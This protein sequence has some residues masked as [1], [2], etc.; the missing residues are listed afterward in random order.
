M[1][2][3][4]KKKN[5][6]IVFEAGAT[7]NGLLSAKKLIDIAVFAGADA[8]K[9][10]YLEHYTDL[11]YDK[12]IK[13]EYEYLVKKH[14]E[15]QIKKHTENY[16]QIVQRR[17]L[18]EK[19]WLNVLQYAKKKRIEIFFTCPSIK[20]LEFCRK[21][22]VSSIKFPSLD[23]NNHER[24]KELK[25][26]N[27]IIQ[28]DTGLA[29]ISE[30]KNTIKKIKNQKKNNQIVVHHCPTGYPAN[31]NNINLKMIGR[32]NK[33]KNII[34]AFSDHSPSYE[35]SS[36]ALAAGAKLIEKTITLNKFTRSPEHIMS[37]EK[38]DAKI[39]VEKIRRLEVIM[40]KSD[41]KINK[42]INNKRNKW[43]RSLHIDE[44]VKKGQK[45]L[46]TKFSFKLP[47]YGIQTKEYRY[48]LNKKFTRN[49]KKHTN[50]FR[51]YLSK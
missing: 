18:T 47:G 2:Q 24:I 12:S 21:N 4:F 46:N 25:R 3:L 34:P 48:L 42:S 15:T 26:Y 22:K 37:L 49:L 36:L 6:I 45:L 33:I 14:N 32:L 1:S 17:S 19:N 27:F 30:I 7:H 5:T 23:I 10:Q 20:S 43:S 39:F 51:E 50:I 31:L 40:G 11:V 16:Y 28:I 9:F 35:I 13:F 38:K 29:T 41:R 44:D 8:V